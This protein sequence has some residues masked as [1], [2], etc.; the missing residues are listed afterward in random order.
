LTKKYKP[1]AA[2]EVFGTIQLSKIRVCTIAEALAQPSEE[3]P[4]KCARGRILGEYIWAYPPG[5]PLGVPGERISRE[6]LDT[7]C[8]LEA[9]G[10]PVYHRGSGYA[11]DESIDKPRFRCVS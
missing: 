7:I 4:A 11:A 9:M 3:V 5:V 10:T 6:L 1:R 8:R 2:C